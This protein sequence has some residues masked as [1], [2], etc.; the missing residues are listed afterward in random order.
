MNPRLSPGGDDPASRELRRALDDARLRGPDDMTLRRGWAALAGLVERP[1]PEGALRWPY[2]AGGLASAATLAVAFALLWP[3]TIGVPTRRPVP[4]PGVMPATSAP[5]VFGMRRL[6]L[7]D[8]VEAQLDATSVMRLDGS[9]PRV[10]GGEVHFSVPKRPPGHPFVVRAEAYRVVVIGTRFGVAVDDERQ[11]EINVREGVVEVWKDGERLSRLTPGDSW[12]S[13]KPVSRGTPANGETVHTVPAEAAADTSLAAK[14]SAKTSTAVA[15]SGRPHAPRKMVAFVMP[16]TRRAPA[17]AP[18]DVASVRAARARGD[19]ARTPQIY[20]ALAKEGGP[21]AE[22][23]AYE[24]GRILNER[25][26]QPA[27]AV[28]AWRRYRTDYPQGILRVEAE[29]SIIETLARSGELDD[30]LSEAADFLRRYPD[31]ERRAEI[32]R[33]AGDLYRLRGDCR[34]AVTAYQTAIVVVRTREVADSA[35]FHRAEC[36]VRLGDA[37]GPDAVRRYLGDYPSGRFS[38]E[39]AALLVGDNRSR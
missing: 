7:E 32:A 12:R 11:V 39:A 28:A 2:F 3:R 14:T 5:E 8:G 33:V 9:N 4:A 34:R 13:P 17:D 16:A 23:A 35:T 10:E 21:A 38:S 19:T 22:N 20:R 1:I 24:V 26:G 27:N 25:M 37:A 30:A 18:A 15:E 6:I 29:V 31:S 36:L